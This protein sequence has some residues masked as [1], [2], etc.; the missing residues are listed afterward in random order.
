MWN[1]IKVYVY[2]A[3][4]LAVL[5]IGYKGYAFYRE[6]QDMKKARDIAEQNAQAAQEESKA[7]AAQVTLLTARVENLQADSTKKKGEIL[8]LKIQVSVLI[9][10]LH[11]QGG[12]SVTVTD[13]TVRVDFEGDR[14]IAHYKG[15]TLGNVATK[16]GTYDLTLSFPQPISV[17]PSLIKDPLD[18]KWKFRTVSNTPGVLVLGTGVLDENTFTALQKYPPP[19][20]P[21]RF[22]LLVGATYQ[23]IYG[24]A[25]IRPWKD[26]WL[27]GGY[28]LN[29]HASE[30]YKNVQINA[31]WTIF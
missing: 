29:N 14:G 12:G 10:S 19:E 6:Y 2:G 26:L 28:K 27:G 16:E 7:K 21:R 15:F 11:G 17:E 20:K 9:D 22:G 8:A 3:V 30:W 1:Q 13:S 4:L 24:G 31:L 5:F 23:D 25:L 18:G